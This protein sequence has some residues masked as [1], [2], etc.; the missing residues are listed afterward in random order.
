MLKSGSHLL[1]FT[2]IK[3]PEYALA[4]EGD[5]I[6]VHVYWNRRICELVFGIPEFSFS[7]IGQLQMVVRRGVVLVVGRS[8]M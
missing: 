3:P 7:S 1:E 8:R 4:L 2:L 6:E 5:C